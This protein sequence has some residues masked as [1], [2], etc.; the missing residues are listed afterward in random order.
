MRILAEIAI[1]HRSEP[2]FY[3][4]SYA[5]VNH[6]VYCVD[7]AGTCYSQLYNIDEKEEIIKVVANC[8]HVNDCTIE[9]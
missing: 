5:Q 8:C 4:A 6:P 3:D 1:T 9:M 7:S 2:Y